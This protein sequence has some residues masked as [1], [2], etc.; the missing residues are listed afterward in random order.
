MCEKIIAAC[1]NDCA[2]CPRYNVPPYTKTA[3]ELHHTAEL[4]YKIGYRDHVVTNEEIACTG[5]K[6][7]NWC[8]YR[9]VKCVNEKHIAHCGQCENYPCDVMKAC[10]TVTGSFISTC[11]KVC[12]P[13]EFETIAQSIFRERKEP[14][15]KLRRQKAFA[16]P[17]RTMQRP[18]YVR[19]FIRVHLADFS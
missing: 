2:V 3:E 19:L 18:F 5:C 1:G 7:E 13:E 12:T 14:D 10:F 16:S 11:K 8:R 6:E 17:F 9:L 15:A 4:W